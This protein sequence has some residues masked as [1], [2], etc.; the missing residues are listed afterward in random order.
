MVQGQVIGHVDGQPVK[1]KID[2]MIR[3]LVHD[4]VQVALN[5]KI[6]DVDP[7]GEAAYC[8]TVSDKARVLGGAVLEAILGRFNR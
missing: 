6:G 5:R 8:R 2:G 4:G 1:A 7:R 3:G